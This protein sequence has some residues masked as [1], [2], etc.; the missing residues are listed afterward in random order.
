MISLLVKIVDLIISFLL[1]GLLL[2]VVVVAPYI[3][4]TSMPLPVAIAIVV[5]VGFILHKLL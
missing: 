5:V 2:C 1:I 4:L 3:L